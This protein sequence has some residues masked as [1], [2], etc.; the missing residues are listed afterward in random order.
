[1]ADPDTEENSK[2]PEG[3]SDGESGSDDAERSVKGEVGA[4]EDVEREE[5]GDEDGRRSHCEKGGRVVRDGGVDRRKTEST[6]LTHAYREKAKI[7]R[8]KV[9]DEE[10]KKNEK[11]RR[12]SPWT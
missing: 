1:V 5:G 3:D 8:D 12:L 6:L 10:K 11:T 2:R 4:Q 7:K 9:S